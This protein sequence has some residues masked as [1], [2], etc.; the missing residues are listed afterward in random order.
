VRPYSG[1]AFWMREEQSGSAGGQVWFGCQ[2]ERCRKAKE[3]NAHL[4]DDLGIGRSPIPEATPLG[5]QPNR[6]GLPIQDAVKSDC[7]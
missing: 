3:T 6:S 4:V 5:E 7:G 1:N 2:R